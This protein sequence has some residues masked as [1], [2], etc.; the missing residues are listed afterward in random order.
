MRHR[1]G[2]V[3]LVLLALS[4]SL[5]QQVSSSDAPASKEDI[6]KLLVV[7]HVR[8]RTQAIMEESVKQT[9]KMLSDILP[10]ELPDA[11]QDEIAKAQSM[12]N[13]MIDGI[14]KD[15]PVDAV[16]QDMVPVYQ[17]HFTK[18]DLEAVIAFYSSPVGQKVL[19]EFP[20]VTSEAMQVSNSHLQPRI[21]AAIDKLKERLAQM[22]EEDQK[23]NP[24]ASNASKPERK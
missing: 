18:A 4:Q 3:L 16:L 9:K 24:P 17:K 12:I 8:E 22:A 21:E 14:G 13:E 7:L 10:K 6:Q 15:Y 19:R 1:S 5:A 2:A 20:A 23:K 11:S